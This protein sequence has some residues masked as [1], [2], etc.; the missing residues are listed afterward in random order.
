MKHIVIPSDHCFLST[1]KQYDTEAEALAAASTKA[2]EE[3]GKE[4]VVL[5]VVASVATEKPVKLVLPVT[6][7]R[8]DKP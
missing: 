4:F 2:G 6:V 1:M 7:T 3:Q 5:A 8:K